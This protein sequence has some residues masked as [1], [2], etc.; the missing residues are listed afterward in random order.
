MLHR[1]PL[2]SLPGVSITS[3]LIDVLHCFYL[4]IVQ[5]WEMKVLWLLFSENVW[6]TASHTLSLIMFR[7]EIATCNKMNRDNGFT[8]VNA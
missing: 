3:F 4:G 8:Q 7:H 5:Q 6:R 1:N 2:L